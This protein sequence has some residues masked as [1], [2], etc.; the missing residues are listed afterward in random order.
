MPTGE[1]VWQM[2][3]L[4]AK[5]QPPFENFRHSDKCRAPSP[6]CHKF[7]GCRYKFY[8]YD[9][10]IRRL[11]RIC[12]VFFGFEG[13]YDSFQAEFQTL[14]KKKE[15]DFNKDW[16]LIC[17]FL[18]WPYIE[19]VREDPKKFIATLPILDD[20]TSEDDGWSDVD[21][22]AM[23][24]LAEETEFDE[25]GVLRQEERAH[26]DAGQYLPALG[27]DLSLRLRPVSLP[28][29]GFRRA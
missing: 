18:G 19:E 4:F 27:L 22:S 24:Q 16:K 13:A 25:N 15:A 9:Y 14:S 3:T 5:L 12:E 11:L 28:L 29:P 23:F 26:R 10:V 8:N 21:F 2:K 1:L 20:T 7:H 17:E 6:C